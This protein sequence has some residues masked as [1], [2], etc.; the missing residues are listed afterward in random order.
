MF[1]FAQTGVMGWIPTPLYTPVEDFLANN[2]TTPLDNI[3]PHQES[4]H[5]HTGVNVKPSQH[6]APMTIHTNN[7]I[8]NTNNTNSDNDNKTNNI[9]KTITTNDD[10]PTDL[11]IKDNIGKLPLMHPRLFAL[12]HPAASLLQEYASKGC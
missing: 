3:I 7:T 6:M 9:I 4:H 8:K 5:P 12:D 11:P 1:P 10:I 2:T